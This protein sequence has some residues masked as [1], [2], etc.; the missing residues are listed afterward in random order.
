MTTSFSRRISADLALARA[1]RWWRSRPAVAGFLLAAAGLVLIFPP[2][3]S[4][5][6]GEMTIAVQTLGGASAL[7]LGLAMLGC[8]IWL[9]SRPPRGVRA[10]IAAGAGLL[11]LAAIPAANLGGFLI[12]TTFG[13]LGAAGSLAWREQEPASAPRPHPPVAEGG[14]E[15]A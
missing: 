11:A 4:L 15:C 8:A 5:T 3:A 2:Y 14:H 6:L 13:L 7:V 9:W 12:A 1:R 10:V